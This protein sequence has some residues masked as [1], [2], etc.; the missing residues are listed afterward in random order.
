MN[1]ALV[2][3]I[4]VGGIALLIAEVFV[5]GGILG[6]LGAIGLGISVYFGFGQHGTG[7]GII[8][9]VIAVIVL[10]LTFFMALK[11]LTLQKTLKKEEG[12]TIEKADLGKLVGAE[13]SALTNL[14][15]SGTARIN[16]SPDVPGSG[17]TKKVDV[18]TEGEMIKK[19]TRIKV[20]KVEGVKVIVRPV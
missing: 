17:S 1:L 5:P 8:Q 6:V 19:N 12:Y 7:F 15:P 10:P 18:V 2:I 4:Y 13:G 14:R 16:L 9:I 20:I 3:L 11:R